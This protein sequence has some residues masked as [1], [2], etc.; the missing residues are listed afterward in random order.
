[1][2][3][4]SPTTLQPSTTPFV[5]LAPFLRLSIAGEDLRPIAQGLL[6]AAEN[7]PE[8]ANLW[9]N[10]AIAMFS[11]S[12]DELGLNIQAQALELQRLYHLPAKQQ[13]AKVRVLMLMTPGNLSANTPL[14]CLLEN[15]DVD[16]ACYY[17]DP[18]QLW[19]DPIPE[20][21]LLLVAVSEEES[22][23]PLLQSLEAAL[24][25]WPRPVLNPPAAILN[26]ARARASQL[27]QDIPGLLMP[28][29]VDLP[30]ETLSTIARGKA[31]LPAQ[32][33][34][35]PVI[36]RPSHSHAGQD[37]ERLD[38]LADLQAYLERVDATRFCLA[39]FVDYSSADGQFRKFRIAMV[40]DQAYA[41]HMAVSSHWMVHYVNAGMYE[42]G[43]KRKEELQFMEQFAAF[44]QRHGSALAQVAARLGLD[45]FCIDGA[46]TRDGRLLI[47]EA[48]HAMVVHA[49]DSE[50]LFPYKQEHMLKVREAVRQLLLQRA[51]IAAPSA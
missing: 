10:L 45:Y 3:E 37:L 11:L 6:Q 19:R 34:D 32:V 18:E 26:V 15:S 35:F 4:F 1:M 42:D 28:H 27:L 2:S 24:Q 40:G 36:V 16:L 5:G 38:T 9:L 20:H 29:T 12:Q 22:R 33:P 7:A 46:E 49:M 21:D 31:P 47:F 30:L 17:L 48:G 23:Y 8:D 25:D 44:R 50:T 43:D 13:P 39:P 14:E 41:C 51:G